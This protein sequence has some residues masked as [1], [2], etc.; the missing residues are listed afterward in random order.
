MSQ[1]PQSIIKPLDE[2]INRH[3][4]EL[5]GFRRSRLGLTTLFRD[6]VHCTCKNTEHFQLAVF[7]S[8][9]ELTHPTTM[10]YDQ[11]HPNAAG[12]SQ[13]ADRWMTALSPFLDSF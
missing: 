10:T 3:S 12:D 9:Q 2:R 8:M 6:S 4:S 5:H 11:V 13:M 1:D 7:K